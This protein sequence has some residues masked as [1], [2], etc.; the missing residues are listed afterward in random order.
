MK[1][2]I[3]DRLQENLGAHEWESHKLSRKL[4]AWATLLEALSEENDALD[5]LEG[6]GMSL[7][8]YSEAQEQMTRSLDEIQVELEQSVKPTLPKSKKTNR[9][10]TRS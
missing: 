7:R 9:R 6:L 10:R 1:K 5:S 8:E 3:E 4:L 2:S